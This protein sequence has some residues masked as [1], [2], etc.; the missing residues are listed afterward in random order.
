M[1]SP[2][3]AEKKIEQPNEPLCRF[4]CNSPCFSLAIAK[5]DR[6]NALIE[7]S[8][9][10]YSHTRT[11]HTHKHTFTIAHVQVTAAA[12]KQKLDNRNVDIGIPLI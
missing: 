10:T 12:L 2:A 11:P 8:C 6:L 7:H 9:Y 4:V 5:T 3:A 1:N